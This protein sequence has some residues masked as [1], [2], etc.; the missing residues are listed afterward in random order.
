MKK[1]TMSFVLL[2]IRVGDYRNAHIAI[3]NQRYCARNETMNKY[4]S[5]LV[6][7][8]RHGKKVNA[9]VKGIYEA[10]V[11]QNFTAK[12]ITVN[13]FNFTELGQY[14]TFK[15]ALAVKNTIL[16]EQQSVAGQ[17]LKPDT[18]EVFR[19]SE[20]I[21]VFE[22][23]IPVKEKTFT[24]KDFDKAVIDIFIGENDHLVRLRLTPD[25]QDALNKIR[26]K[27]L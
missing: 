8:L 27:F 14:S 2:G 5:S 22:S 24:V 12:D 25:L 16:K 7:S 17:N 9:C 18:I 19:M 13:T 3:M 6:Q 4:R 26:Q 23:P 10:A 20:G 11:A 15:A 21:S 1:V